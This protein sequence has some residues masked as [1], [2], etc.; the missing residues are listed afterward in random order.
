VINN[1]AGALNVVT[2]V[3]KTKVTVCPAVIVAG[4]VKV[5][6]EAIVV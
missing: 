5:R 4:V 6:P 2:P 3:L 1:P